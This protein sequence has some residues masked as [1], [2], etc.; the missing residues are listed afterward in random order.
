M[1]HF[2]EMGELRKEIARLNQVI[3]DL[4]LEIATYRS[5]LMLVSLPPSTVVMPPPPILDRSAKV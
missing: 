2:E 1:S 5:R 4:Q 3:V